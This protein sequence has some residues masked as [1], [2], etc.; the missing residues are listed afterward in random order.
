METLKVISLKSTIKSFSWNDG[1]FAIQ[2][3]QGEI[4]YLW[5]I[6][7]GKLDKHEDGTPNITCV[8]INNKGITKTDLNISI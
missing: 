1:L 6:I 3:K 2:K 8:G 5:K 7:N 4:L